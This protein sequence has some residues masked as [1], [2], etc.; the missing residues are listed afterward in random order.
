M[1]LANPAYAPVFKGPLEG[2]ATNYL[3]KNYWRVEATQ[4][5]DDCM[6]EAQCVFY[7]LKTRYADTGAVTEPKHFMALYKTSMTRRFTDLANDNTSRRWEVVVSEGPDGEIYEP[8]GETDNDGGLAV[9][10][11][12][13]PAEVVQVLNLFLSCPQ[14]ILDMALSTWRTSGSKKICQLLGIDERRD[15]MQETFDHFDVSS[16]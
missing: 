3:K 14:E 15:V 12:Q 16:K 6:Q 11:R 5:W 4:E 1:P 13:A 7:K 8:M 10:L 2:W 9:L